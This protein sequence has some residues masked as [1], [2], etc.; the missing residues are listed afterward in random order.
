MPR[1]RHRNVTETPE[2]LAACWHANAD[3]VPQSLLT[4]TIE[5]RAE[6]LTELA[7][8]NTIKPV[9]VRALA[10][11]LLVASQPPWPEQIAALVDHVLGQRPGHKAGGWYYFELERRGRRPQGVEA[12]RASAWYFAMV[13]DDY[14]FTKYRRVLTRDA[15]VKLLKTMG[16]KTT[17]NLISKW[18]GEH[19]GVEPGTPGY[20]PTIPT[21]APRLTADEALEL[22]RTFGPGVGR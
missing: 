20:V 18:R 7:K 22:R 14:C 6:R 13:I 19:Y 10:R 5:E 12:F 8:N 21:T 1:R 17:M 11:D 3:R 2:W 15:L 16:L 9:L 4:G